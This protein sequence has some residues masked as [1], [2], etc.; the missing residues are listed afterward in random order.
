[1]WS[2]AALESGLKFTCFH[3]SSMK[4]S[5]QILIGP[6][7]VSR[8]LCP[9]QQ[10]CG[11]RLERCGETSSTSWLE[12]DQCRNLS[13]FLAYA[14]PFICSISECKSFSYQD[15]QQILTIVLLFGLRSIG[16]IFNEQRNL[17]I[18]NQCEFHS[19]VLWI[20][21]KDPHPLKQSFILIFCS[22]EVIIYFRHVNCIQTAVR[23]KWMWLL[24]S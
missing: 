7:S 15:F 16:L 13:I 1:M 4:L 18:G 24:I 5:K 14:E 21:L 17:K 8:I 6:S 22:L 2:R 20:Q 3:N 11:N 9:E 10:L 12:Q 23:I 19:G